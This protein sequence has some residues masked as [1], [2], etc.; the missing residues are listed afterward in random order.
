[1]GTLWYGK[2]TKSNRVRGDS[3]CHKRK[4]PPSGVGSSIP[5]DRMNFEEGRKV[6]KREIHCKK[7]DS[8]KTSR[9]KAPSD[10]FCFKGRGEK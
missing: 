1:M 2:G 6:G 4:N 8:Q 5:L 9:N 3:N 7:G 10:Q